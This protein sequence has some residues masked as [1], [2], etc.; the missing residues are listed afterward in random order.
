MSRW[1]RLYDETLN[2][3]KILKLSDKSYRIWTQIL[4]ATS[5]NGG[6]I[7]P[8]ED[9]AIMLRIKPEKL[10]PELEKLIA[11]ELIDHDDLGMRPHNWDKR[12][13]KSDVTDPTAATR[14]QRHRNKTRNATV[15]PIRPDTEQR[16]NT[17]QNPLKGADAPSPEKQ[18]FD[19]SVEIGVGR[20]M[21]AKLRK[22]LGGDLSAARAKLEEAATKS[23][24]I[25]WL[26][27][28]TGPP[29]AAPQTIKEVKQTAYHDAYQDLKNA[30]NQVRESENSGGEVVRFLPSVTSQ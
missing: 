19:R 8:F 29:R 15:T 14:M 5:I 16:Q 2:D 22:S 3:P 20:G 27:A 21:A 25:E 18:F 9:L 17:E 28:T 24:P 6:K 10:Q 13:Y 7:P 1:F 30:A 11:A 12:Q 4:C 23:S 26:A